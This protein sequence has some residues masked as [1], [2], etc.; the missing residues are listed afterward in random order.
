MEAGAAGG[1]L[2]EGA[3]AV[4]PSPLPKASSS[5]TQAQEVNSSR[6]TSEENRRRE[7]DD[8][9]LAKR[10]QEQE[11]LELAIRQSQLQQ[12]Q[13]EE[14]EMLLRQSQLQQNEQAEVEMAIRQSQ[15][16]H[17]EEN[18]RTVIERSLEERGGIDIQIMILA[19]IKYLES[20]YIT[21]KPAQVKVTRTGNCLPDSMVVITDPNVNEQNLPIKSSAFR[22][23]VVNTAIQAI[24]TATE[25][26]LKK[27]M[28]LA[29]RVEGE[30]GP[31][32]RQ[33]LEAL[34]RSY[35]REYAYTKEG[36]D[37][38]ALLTAFHL[39]R[40]ILIVDIHAKRSPSVGIIHPDL[41]FARN[42]AS[43]PPS[44]PLVLVRSA[45]HFEP[46]LIE[47]DSEANLWRIYNERRQIDFPTEADAESAPAPATTFTTAETESQAL[48]PPPTAD[49]APVPATTLTT[50]KAE[51]QAAPPP[52]TA[53][54]APVP[55]STLTTAKAESQAA[56]PPTAADSAPATVTT[57]TT[58]K[59][60]SQAVQPPPTADSAPAPAK[61]LTTAEAESQ[62]VPPPTTADSAPAPATT[63]TTAEAESQAAPSPSTT[64][65]ALQANPPLPAA[66]TASTLVAAAPP[67]TESGPEPPIE[68]AAAPTAHVASGPTTSSTTTEAESQADG[69]FLRQLRDLPHV[70]DSESTFSAAVRRRQDAGRPVH[71]PLLQLTDVVNGS[72]TAGLNV[73]LST[74]LGVFLND[75]PNVQSQL[76]RQLRQYVLAPPGTRGT[77]DELC[78]LMA[79]EV[80]KVPQLNYHNDARPSESIDFLEALIYSVGEVLTDDQ[81]VEF[82]KL[83]YVNFQ[84]WLN[85]LNCNNNT[86]ATKSQLVLKLPLVD[87][88]NR[89]VGSLREA[90]QSL[91]DCNERHEVNEACTAGCGARKTIKR[92]KIINPPR[93]LYL[94]FDRHCR[95]A[96]QKI[97]VNYEIYLPQ[98]QHHPFRLN[99]IVSHTN[100]NGFYADIVDGEQGVWRSN[101]DQEPR[102][103]LEREYNDGQFNG[104]IFVYERLPRTQSRY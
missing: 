8:N 104:Q 35:G 88:H 62:A 79:E 56:L 30:E 26:E 33:Q 77:T 52:P 9:Q 23:D 58:A 64:A 101:Q 82:K 81:K 83:V 2:E 40:P 95:K 66:T 24:R 68:L 97:E 4:A 51:S 17:E 102:Q 84:V 75:L 73:F 98:Y 61:T 5:R 11:D 43:H 10:L 38:I 42:D 94:Y 57:T 80:P 45:D 47:S 46:L 13:E 59:A 90:L 14:V 70:S 92:S 74:E 12:V 60:D 15:I 36:G 32:N 65:P 76:L 1:R 55:A 91:K 25:A 50:A 28:D 53:D 39:Q 3:G 20:K 48:P 6:P 89:P 19:A 72:S 34:I 21:A 86:S 31:Q 87:Q 41:I 103:A 99:S 71:A 7:E 49:S 85:C 37:I 54:L 78:R 67:P 100:D 69:A 29:T 63:L 27:L 18:M 96:S 22:K 93:V 44:V 16:T